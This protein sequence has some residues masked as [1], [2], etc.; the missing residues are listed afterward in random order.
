MQARFLVIS[1]VPLQTKQDR[2]GARHASRYE[3]THGR[4]T[5]DIKDDED[6]LILLAQRKFEAREILREAAWHRVQEAAVADA[7][8][9]EV[10]TTLE[11]AY[12]RIVPSTAAPPFAIH[13]SHCV[14]MCGGYFGCVRCA[15]VCGFGTKNPLSSSCRGGA[16]QSSYG[17]IRRLIAGVLPHVQ[18]GGRDGCD[19]PSGE[20]Q[21]T[22]RRWQAA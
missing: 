8:W 20:Q 10:V 16:P 11:D 5:R 4:C 7:A 9:K 22:P 15:T 1:R 21:P 19:W 13:R 12:L 3:E 2:I 17:P 18:R 6:R 14:V